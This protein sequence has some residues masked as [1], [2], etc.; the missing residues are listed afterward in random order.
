[1]DKY[2]AVII[3]NEYY[4]I[5]NGTT[6]NNYIIARLYDDLKELKEDCS[7]LK[8]YKIKELIIDYEL[9]LISERFI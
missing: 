2:F 8:D 9:N 4:D 5:W 6:T 7:N 1:M 3:N